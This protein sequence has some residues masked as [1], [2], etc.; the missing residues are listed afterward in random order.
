[1]AVCMGEDMLLG[2]LTVV[3]LEVKVLKIMQL[4]QYNYCYNRCSEFYDDTLDKR[5]PDV[6]CPIFLVLNS[7]LMRIV[8]KQ[9]LAHW[10]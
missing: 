7:K 2:T 5:R 10:K 6:H 3:Y 1:M 8:Y 9:C 4:Y